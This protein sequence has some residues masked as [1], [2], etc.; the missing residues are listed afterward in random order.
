MVDDQDRLTGVTAVGVD[1]T[2]FLRATSTLDPAGAA[3]NDVQQP[4]V[5]R[6]GVRSAMSVAQWVRTVDWLTAWDEA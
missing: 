2:A 4:A 1:E 6:P 5:G 3:R